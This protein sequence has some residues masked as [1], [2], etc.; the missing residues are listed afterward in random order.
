MSHNEQF[1]NAFFLY[2]FKQKAELSK[3]SSDKYYYEYQ[4]REEKKL[5]HYLHTQP[6][7]PPRQ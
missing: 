4:V 1:K 7:K 6:H 2:H 3:N 5:L